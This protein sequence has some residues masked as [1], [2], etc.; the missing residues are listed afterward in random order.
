MP[1]LRKMTWHVLPVGPVY[2]LMVELRN[3]Q[4]RVDRDRRRWVAGVSLSDDGRVISAALVPCYNRGWDCRPEI[5]AERSLAVPRRVAALYAKVQRGDAKRAA[6]AAVL[7]AELAELQATVLDELLQSEPHGAE[8]ILA[9]GVH[10]CGLWRRQRHALT[11]YLSLCDAARLADL[12]GLNVIDAF[13]A[14]DLA[15]DGLGGPLLAGPQWVL[16]HDAQRNRVLVDLGESVRVTWL[17]A[18]RDCEGLARVAAFDAGPGMR[19]LDRLVAKWTDARQP[20]QI[21]THRQAAYD[22]AAQGTAIDELMAVWL[23]NPYFSQ[24]LPRWHGLGVATK[25]FCD[26]A[27]QLSAGRG[28]SLCDVLCTATHFIAAHVARGLANH[29]PAGVRIDDV[30]L[31]GDGQHNSLLTQLLAEKISGVAWKREAELDVPAAALAPACVAILALLHLDQTP[32]NLLAVTGA[33]KGRV[34]G[35]LTP[36]SP[37][38]WQQLVKS[39]TDTKPAVLSLRSAL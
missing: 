31:T 27:V 25:T 12:T 17:P 19:L 7:A 10:D 39:L 3:P 38:R 2:S 16:L 1:G 34:L 4:L 8:R 5:V 23:A 36:G 32:A 14:R 20:H 29:L 30:V 6:V 24:P 37:Q 28:W 21:S 11:G 15:Q 26:A 35:R 22:L 13:A 9:V 18:A 33:R